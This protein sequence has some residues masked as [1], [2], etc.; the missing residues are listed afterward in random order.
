MAVEVRGERAA[1]L[2]EVLAVIGRAFGDEG[3]TVAA[4]WREITAT[5]ERSEGFVAIDGESIVGHV[6]LS[7]GWLD[8]RRALV[9]ITVL[10]PL[11]VEP[12]RQRQGIGTALLAAASGAALRRTPVVVLEG[13]PAYYSARGF[14][15]AGDVGIT[16]ASDRIPPPACQVMTGAAFEPWMAGRVIYP[17]VWWRHDA[18]GL[19]DPQ[20]AEIERALADPSVISADPSVNHADPS[21][22]SV[23]RADY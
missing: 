7:R 2:D 1:D 13:D 16:P 3:P 17:D 11:S 10:S 4:I 5:D 15:P 21:V 14:A 6:G 19:R 18:T 20:L 8:A 23:D 9:D 22:N 12:D